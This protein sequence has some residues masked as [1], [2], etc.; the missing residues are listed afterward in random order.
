M[1]HGCLLANCYDLLHL[2]YRCDRV[3]CNRDENAKP[4]G[5]LVNG[6]IHGSCDAR[7]GVGRNHLE[8]DEIG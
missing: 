2:M 8:L 3:F 6:E 5:L 1:L 7:G 4:A